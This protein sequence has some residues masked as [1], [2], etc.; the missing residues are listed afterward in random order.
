MSTIRINFAYNSFLT[1]SNYIINLILFP[2]CARVLGVA[3]FGTTTFVQNV[4]EYFV[5]IAMMGIT[6]IGVREIAKQNNKE[7]L[8]QCYSSLLVLNM[9]YTIISLS[10]FLPLIILIDRFLELKVLFVLGAFYILFS[11]FK[12]EWLFRGIE[13]FKYI[14]IRNIVIK[15]LY[16]GLV[17]LLVKNSNDY[18]LFYIL[19][20]MMTV[21][22][23]TINYLYARKFVHFSL[24][25]ITPF[26]YLKSSLS[27]GLYSI[28][29]SMYTTF[30]VIFLGMVW[31]DIQVGFYTTAIKLYTVIVGFYSAFTGVMMP[32]LSSILGK[33]GEREYK[34][35]VDKSLTLLYTVSIPCIFVLLILAPEVVTLL[36][37]KEYGPSIGMSRIVIPVL[38]VVGLGQILSFQVLIPRGMDKSTLQAS[39]VGASVGIGFNLWLTTSYGAVGTC[40]TVFLTEICVTSF[41]LYISLKKNLFEV[42]K[43]NFFRHLTAGIPYVFI[44]YFFH[45]ILKGN[46]ILVPIVSS[47]VC[48]IWF[49]FSQTRLLKNDI[50]INALSLIMK[51]T[52]K[53]Q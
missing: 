35:L 7:Q 49:I 50:V 33:N 29:T 52:H 14:T 24:K 11:S 18:V 19:T 23:A 48:L 28:L 44:C 39:I 36:A 10:L 20:V 22:N 43:N 53:V 26:K 45:V 31:N 30:N 27:L 9:L 37:G 5:F 38:F 3:R 42:D 12:I 41:Y 32:R 4:V 40:V 8:N 1:V 25:G 15:L 13:N 34:Q 16:V 21:L 46:T 47:L 51:K 17:F 2:Y 6:H